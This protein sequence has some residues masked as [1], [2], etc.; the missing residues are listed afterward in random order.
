[1]V[2]GAHVVGAAAAAARTRA[3]RR[4][5]VMVALAPRRTFP[6]FVTAS[7]WR[8]AFQATWEAARKARGVEYADNGTVVP[9]TTNGDAVTL[10][11]AWSDAAGRGRF[12]LWYQFAAVA[13]GWS[14]K[15]D[16]L[17]VS[18]RQR[19]GLY[20]TE[21]GNELWLAMFAL[22]GDLDDEGATSPRLATDTAFDDPVWVATLRAELQQDGARATFKIPTIFCT[23]KRTGRRRLPRPP[24]DAN[25]RG[26]IN[27]IDPTGPRL[28][29][30]K[31]GDCAPLM[32]DDPITVIT[33]DVGKLAVFAFVA[34][35]LLR[36]KRQRREG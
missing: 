12:P 31:R 2:P 22:S 30:D 8:T 9:I 25:G 10:V 35:L 17:D 36:G 20:P 27:P 6:A 3:A 13:Y 7:S 24:C 14:P 15:R 4:S 28:P 33:K 29:C 23:D 11:R 26:P 21:I 32:F 19:D 1:V 34:W 18:S 16:R 5:G